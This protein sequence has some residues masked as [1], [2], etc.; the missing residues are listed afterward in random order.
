V[1]KQFLNHIERNNLCKTTDKI[2]LAVSGGIDSM[3]MFHL[4]KEAGFN[5]GVAHCNFQLRGE[6][7]VADETLVNIACVENAIP[8]HHVRFNTEEYATEKKLSIQVAARELRYAFFQSIAEQCR[9]TKIATAHHLNDSFETVILNLVRGTG[10][11]GLT[12]IPVLNRNVI[13]PLLFATRQQIEDYA[14]F[15]RLSWRNDQS[16][17]SNDY[18][19]NFIRNEIIPR[20]KTLNPNLVET[21]ARTEEKLNA[22]ALI[23]LEYIEKIKKQSWREIDSRIYI[24]K[25]DITNSIAPAL[26]LSELFKHYGFNFSQ[27]LAIVDTHQTGKKFFSNS[28]SLFIT[29][30]DFV[31][32]ALVKDVE[33]SEVIVIDDDTIGVTKG[34]RTLTL[35]KVGISEFELRM[36]NDIAQLDFDKIKFPIQWRTWKPGDTFIPLGMHESKKISDYLVD[37][38]MHLFDKKSVA[39]LESGGEIIWLVGHRI[40]DRFKVTAATKSV[41]IIE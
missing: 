34:E 18:Q 40:N 39:V 2:L 9:Y 21:F 15:L 38:K 29:A 26:I 22:S 14:N 30:G 8:F 3:V 4:F 19:R 5:F 41:L 10:I 16:N 6:E 20:L 36:N 1:V 31:V 32:S 37:I 7:S 27:C 23:Q 35:K 28:H 33:P 24:K 17:F 13:R 11:N 25:Q 12:G